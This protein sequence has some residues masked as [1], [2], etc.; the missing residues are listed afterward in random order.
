MD[1][2]RPHSH[3]AEYIVTLVTPPNSSPPSVPTPLAAARSGG[4]AG[5][6]LATCAVLAA[7]CAEAKQQLREV[8]AA[9]PSLPLV[10]FLSSL[11]RCCH[12][13][14]DHSDVSFF[15]QEKSCCTS[16]SSTPLTQSS[17]VAYLLIQLRNSTRAALS[18]PGWF[19][20]TRVLVPRA[21]A[22]EPPVGNLP[23]RRLHRRTHGRRRHRHDHHAD[24]VARGRGACGLGRGQPPQEEEEEEEEEEGGCL[25]G[26]NKWKGGNNKP[27]SGD[28]SYVATKLDTDGDQAMDLSEFLTVADSGK[29]YVSRV[30]VLT[31]AFFFI[32]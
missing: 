32:N 23:R 5:A 22:D 2:Y 15:C 31:T 13:L 16:F 10:F 4:W 7:C 8:R 11:L 27:G 26:N 6:L 14:Q 9:P 21:C 29:V 20:L 17:H 24:A 12:V 18:L 19:V 25:G 1:L 3:S 28:W 30:R